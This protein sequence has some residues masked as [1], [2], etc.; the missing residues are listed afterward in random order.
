M[1][2]HVYEY[3]R[4]NISSNVLQNELLLEITEKIKEIAKKSRKPE[5][6]FRKVEKLL[7]KY[8]FRAGQGYEI[9][10]DENKIILYDRRYVVNK[11]GVVEYSC[12]Y[13]KVIIEI[14]DE[15]SEL[16]DSLEK[17]IEEIDDKAIYEVYV[18]AGNDGYLYAVFY[19]FI[20]NND[21]DDVIYEITGEDLKYYLRE[22][23]KYVKEV[24]KEFPG[25]A[26]GEEVEQ[27]PIQT[28]NPYAVGGDSWGWE[29][30]K[31]ELTITV[32]YTT[33]MGYHFY[34]FSEEITFKKIDHK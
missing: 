11:Y 34:R 19:D 13:D 14:L 15:K 9:D 22:W 33:R 27:V 32:R 8:K 1:K 29:G 12:G 10:K 26:Y 23:I 24:D 25:F 3:S 7:G 6:F 28:Q 17:Y 31:D 30:T 18:N 5:A 2:V 21:E 16:I 4:D 20:D